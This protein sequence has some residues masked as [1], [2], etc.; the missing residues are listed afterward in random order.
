VYVTIPSLKRN[1]S[2]TARA[3]GVAALDHLE[4]SLRAAPRAGLETGSRPGGLRDDGRF[5]DYSVGPTWTRAGSRRCS[6]STTR[7][8]RLIGESERLIAHFQRLLVDAL[9]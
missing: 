2:S 1:F 7:S 9:A 3:G 5:L 4:G 6:P 8:A